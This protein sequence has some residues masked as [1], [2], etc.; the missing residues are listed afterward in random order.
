MGSRVQG[1]RVQV[2][3]NWVPGLWII[4][5]AFGQVYGFEVLGPIGFWIPPNLPRLSKDWRFA[6]LLNTPVKL[7]HEGVKP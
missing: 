7:P 5:T 1:L 2:P 6:K 4:L 3:N